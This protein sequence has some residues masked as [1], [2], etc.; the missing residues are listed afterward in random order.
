MVA[1]FII[2]VSLLLRENSTTIVA[3]VPLQKLNGCFD[4]AVVVLA[5]CSPQ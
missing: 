1:L 2:E 4:L 3:A 5:G